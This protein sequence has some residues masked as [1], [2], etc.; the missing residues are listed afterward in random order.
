MEQTDS[1]K[2]LTDQII[3]VIKEYEITFKR[4][5][6]TAGKLDKETME[7]RKGLFQVH[8]QKWIL[9]SL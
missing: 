3:I 1:Y 8:M 2:R 5:G 9:S 7:T 4:P 6:H